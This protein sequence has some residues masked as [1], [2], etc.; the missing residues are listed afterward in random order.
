MSAWCRVDCYERQ[1]HVASFSMDQTVICVEGT[2]PVS[3]KN[4][5]AFAALPSRSEDSKVAKVKSCIGKVCL[6][7]SPSLIPI[8]SSSCLQIGL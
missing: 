3:D 4:R 1:H 2:H 8:L 7:V 6:C 5:I